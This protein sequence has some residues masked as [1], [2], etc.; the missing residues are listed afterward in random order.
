MTD[1]QKVFMLQKYLKAKFGLET[2]DE[3]QTKSVYAPDVVLPVG[4]KDRADDDTD[5]LSNINDEDAFNTY[6]FDNAENYKRSCLTEC[7]WVWDRLK[8]RVY[9]F[10]NSSWEYPI[11]VWEDMYNHER[12]WI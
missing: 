11:W 12:V 9:L 10:S 6:G 2:D 4:N 1:K 7:Y 8:K 5:I 3:G